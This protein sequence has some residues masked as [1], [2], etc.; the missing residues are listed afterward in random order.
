MSSD[1]C[2]NRQSNDDDNG[3]MASNQ[4]GMHRREKEIHTMFLM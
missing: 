2:I 4:F 3:S 1:A